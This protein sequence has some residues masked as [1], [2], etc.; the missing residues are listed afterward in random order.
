MDR[1]SIAGPVFMHLEAVSAPNWKAAES[2]T[3][4]INTL[5]ASFWAKSCSCLLDSGF[6]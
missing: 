3:G 1:K 6:R 2:I 5:S 4:Q